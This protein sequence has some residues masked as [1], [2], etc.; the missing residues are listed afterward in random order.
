MHSEEIAM[1][2]MRTDNYAARTRET[3]TRNQEVARTILEQFGGGRLAVMTGAHSFVAI[4]QGLQFSLKHGAKDGMP[5][6]T[7]QLKPQNRKTKG[8]GD[9]MT[10]KVQVIA[11]S[12][13]EWCGNGKTFDTVEDATAYAVDLY[14][15][16]TA[17][18]EWRIVDSDGGVWESSITSQITK[19]KV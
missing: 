8:H 6:H 2:S 1:D 11:D 16:W 13:G 15:R 7:A 5:R 17:V 10:Y 12:S 4:D 9:N 3:M 19:L 14:S 18:R